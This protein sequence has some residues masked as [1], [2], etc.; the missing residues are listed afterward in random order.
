MSIAVL[1][2]LPPLLGHI[3]AYSRE[4]YL[5]TEYI[6]V[7]FIKSLVSHEYEKPHQ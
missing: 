1:T 4:V 3:G 6:Y 2:E 5:K 7:S